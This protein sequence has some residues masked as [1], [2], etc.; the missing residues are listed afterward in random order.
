MDLIAVLRRRSTF[1]QA[2]NPNPNPTREDENYN[3][4]KDA[5]NQADAS[6]NGLDFRV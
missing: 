1:R 5:E 4:T 6:L 2:L 3:T